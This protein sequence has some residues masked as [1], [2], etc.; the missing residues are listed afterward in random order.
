MGALLSSRRTEG[1]RSF[2]VERSRAPPNLVEEEPEGVEGVFGPGNVSSWVALKEH[3]PWDAP[4]KV[5]AEAVRPNTHARNS[6]RISI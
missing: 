2:G 4:V 3:E 5:L 1:R 6:H